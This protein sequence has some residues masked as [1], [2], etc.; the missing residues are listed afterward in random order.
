MPLRHRRS[1]WAVASS[2]KSPRN[3]EFT[4]RTDGDPLQR[5]LI[6]LSRRPRAFHAGTVCTLRAISTGPL[7][8]VTAFMSFL[9]II[10]P[11]A[12]RRGCRQAR[13]SDPLLLV[14]AARATRA[15]QPAA[16][17]ASRRRPAPHA[18][19][20][21]PHRRTPSA[22]SA[23][24]PPA[25]WPAAGTGS[26][27]ASAQQRGRWWATAALLPPRAP[28]RPSDADRASAAAARCHHL[29]RRRGGCWPRRPPAAA[30]GGT[31]PVA[32]PCWRLLH[33]AEP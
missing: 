16:A 8:S 30:V 18:A 9:C 14:D 31:L 5:L 10:S 20:S 4:T 12:W 15:Q 6:F 22:P 33:A 24:P 17:G 1:S 3:G 11:D 28:T 32:L 13:K 21:R 27:S 2:K 29:L 23:G 25:V 26:A 19:A 7:C